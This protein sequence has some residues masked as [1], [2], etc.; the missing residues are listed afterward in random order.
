MG[1][2]YY[3][4][5][6][7]AFVTSKTETRDPYAALLDLKDECHVDLRKPTFLSSFGAGIGGT[8]L[9]KGKLSKYYRSSSNHKLYLLPKESFVSAEVC[10]KPIGQGASFCT[11][12][13]CKIQKHLK[14]NRLDICKGNLYV[15]WIQNTAF[16]LPTI[17]SSYLDNDILVSWLK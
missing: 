3:R 4:H 16:L 15:Y 12:K 10:G 5:D 13:M 14:L 2:K 1:H 11:N 6:D 9:T 8:P 17:S 7:V